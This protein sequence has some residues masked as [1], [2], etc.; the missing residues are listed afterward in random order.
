[1]N[2]TKKEL[3]SRKLAQIRSEQWQL[4]SCIARNKRLE[5]QLQAK[6]EEVLERVVGTLYEKRKELLDLLSRF[7]SEDVKRDKIKEELI[8]KLEK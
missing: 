7:E 4:T 8:K 1:M 2:N 5:K 3:K 6:E